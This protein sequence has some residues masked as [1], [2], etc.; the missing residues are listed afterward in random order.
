MLGCRRT[1]LRTAGELSSCSSEVC[2]ERG[3]DAFRIGRQ[4]MIVRLVVVTCPPYANSASSK[5][6]ATFNTL[7][8]RVLMLRCVISRLLLPANAGDSTPFRSF[9]LEA[10]RVLH[11][12]V[13]D[14]QEGSGGRAS[15]ASRSCLEEKR[16]RW[17]EGSK[18]D[19]C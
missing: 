5:L 17:R 3:L 4:G 10:L 9:F 12:S 18:I 13:N 8:S 1:W 6:T 11:C 15:L 19:K 16:S 14:T 2:L 7:P